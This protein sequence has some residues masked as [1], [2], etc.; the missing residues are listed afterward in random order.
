MK[1][2]KKILLILMVSAA[3][4][5]CSQKKLISIPITYTQPYCGGARPSE[6]ILAEAAKPKP[7][8]NKTII[9]VS[10]KGKVDSLK[11]D[12]TGVLKTNLKV[13]TYKLF[14]PWRYYKKADAGMKVS[15]FDLTCLKTEWM[16]EIK[17]LTITKTET[18][19]LDKNEI[20]ERC[21]WSLP[22]ILE[23][24]KPPARE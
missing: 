23:G 9:I 8:S 6:E 2:S 10:Q 18:K 16:K 3:L 20:I 14:E 4:I 19:I 22:C 12:A 17:E 24:S 15:D 13:G 21:P 5:S 7:Y 1:I 11:T